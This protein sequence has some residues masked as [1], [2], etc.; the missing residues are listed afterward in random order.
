MG[1]DSVWSWC[2]HLHQPEDYQLLLRILEKVIH[3]KDMEIP[4]TYG[5]MI[6]VVLLFIGN[7]VI[8]GVGFI[9]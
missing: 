2:F 3:K 4:I 7:W 8:V 1:G 9:C 5:E 6:K